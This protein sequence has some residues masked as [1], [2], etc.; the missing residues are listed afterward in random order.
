MTPQPVLI[1][2]INILVG[3][4]QP[5]G[6]PTEYQFECLMPTDAKVDELA[7]WIDAFFQR[8]DQ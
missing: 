6:I 3:D 4:E 5:E 1:T 7:S 2:K 8:R